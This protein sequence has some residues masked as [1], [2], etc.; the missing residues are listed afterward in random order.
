MIAGQAGKRLCIITNSMIYRRNTHKTTRMIWNTWYNYQSMLL[1]FLHTLQCH[2]RHLPHIYSVLNPRTCRWT[3]P[4][5]LLRLLL[6]PDPDS[7]APDLP[8]VDQHPCTGQFTGCPTRSPWLAG[9]PGAGSQEALLVP[10]HLHLLHNHHRHAR[11][12]AVQ[13][14]ESGG[15][16][17]LV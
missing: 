16:V 17:T 12:P 7:S 10:N 6:P 4:M 5:Q 3:L 15:D 8:P 11:L 2:I 13:T 9:K 1:V 14:E